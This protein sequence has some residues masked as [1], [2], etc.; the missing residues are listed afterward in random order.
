MSALFGMIRPMQPP[1]RQ[2]GNQPI[3]ARQ[4]TSATPLARRPNSVPLPPTEAPQRPLRSSRKIR[5]SPR[6]VSLA[7][8]IV[9]VFLVGSLGFWRASSKPALPS[10]V[11]QQLS[12]GVYFPKAKTTV[13]TIDK[14]TIRYQA[15]G[16]L[17][18]YTAKLA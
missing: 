11:A 15:S 14:G 6:S 17:F 16:G 4:Y 13:A 18:S 10:T 8:V 3:R 9:G 2:T 1:S 12:F 5:M 7:L